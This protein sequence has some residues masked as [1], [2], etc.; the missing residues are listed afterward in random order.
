MRRI[1]LLSLLSSSLFLA[2]NGGEDEADSLSVVTD[3]GTATVAAPLDWPGIAAVPNLDDD[4]S[5]GEPDYDHALLYVGDDDYAEVSILAPQGFELSVSGGSVRVW[6]EGEPILE[7]GTAAWSFGGRDEA[8]VFQ[9]EVGAYRASGTLSVLDKGT[10]QV[11]EV[12]ITGAPL[13][14]NHHIQPSELV[15]AVFFMSTGYNNTAMIEGYEAVLGDAFERVSGMKYNDPW[16]QDEI[17]FAT[18]SAPAGQLDVVIDSIRNGQYGPGYGLDDLPEDEF[19]GP[20]WA[21][22]TW[23][24]GYATSQDYFGNLE[25]IPPLTVG[26]VNYPYGRLYY[27]LN[28]SLSP[29]DSL[30]EM[31]D[32]QALQAPFTL[33]VSWLCVGHVDEF[34]TTVPAPGSRLGWKLVYSDVD[35][36]WQ[37]LEGMDPET[38]LT[39]YQSTSY[40]P[41]D[42]IGDMLADKALRSLNEELK[43]DYLAPNLDI[44]KSELGLLDEDIILIPG[45][46]EEVS[47][48]GGTTAAAFPGM[49]NLIVANAPD[50][51]PTLFVA[52]PFLRTDTE[53]IASDPMAAAFEALMPGDLDVVFLDDWQVYHLMLGEVHCGSNVVRSPDEAPSWWVDARHLLEAE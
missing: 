10:G 53:D 17:E 41:W 13:I 3:L 7:E 24:S 47:G 40:K 48:C 34:V 28:G 35:L 23:G 8:L 1:G 46:F 25:V 4:D 2:C 21:V 52:D 5:D 22:G 16:L 36:A 32:D 29:N 9:V 38:E 26:D 43:A 15:M 6:Y 39:R 49:A 27:G 14:L 45:L 33:D 51:T 50:G 30:R 19:E 44:L 42:T 18:S 37:V 20:G 11:L 12:P 31:L